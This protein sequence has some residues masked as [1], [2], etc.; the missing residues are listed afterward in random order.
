MALTRI[1]AGAAS[2]AVG[3]SSVAAAFGG[4]AATVGRTALVGGG[5][6]ALGGAALLKAPDGV[7]KKG[8]DA[9]TDL[10]AKAAGL[11]VGLSGAVVEGGAEAFKKIL[12]ETVAPAA[13]EN[14]LYALVPLVAGMKLLGGGGW[15]EAGKVMALLSA[16]IHIAEEYGLKLPGVDMKGLSGSFNRAMVGI[17]EKDLAGAIPDAVKPGLG[18]PLPAPEM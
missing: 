13:K 7:M 3:S 15:M 11:G 16:V 6:A 4:A 10:T 1:F 14:G 5:V 18:G 17:S 12:D 8:F 2:S 9:V